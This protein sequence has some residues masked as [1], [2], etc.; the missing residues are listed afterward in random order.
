MLEDFNIRVKA[1]WVLRYLAQ[2]TYIVYMK[3]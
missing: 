1:G 3:C 2:I